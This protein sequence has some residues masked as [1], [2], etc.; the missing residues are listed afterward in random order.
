MSFVDEHE[1]TEIDDPVEEIIQ[2]EEKKPVKVKDPDN[3]DGDDAPA[4]GDA[5]A[6]DADADADPDAK[7][8]FDPTKFQWT[9]SNGNPKTLSKILHKKFQANDVKSSFNLSNEL[10]L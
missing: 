7:P 4:D 3:P 1:P 10:I 6:D 2:V 5:P 8:K 9:I